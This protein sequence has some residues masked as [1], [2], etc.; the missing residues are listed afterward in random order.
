MDFPSDAA[1][2]QIQLHRTIGCHDLRV[3]E[4]TIR[5]SNH[6]LRAVGILEFHGGE[7][8]RKRFYFGDPW[9]LPTWRGQGVEPYRPPRMR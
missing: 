9:E 5:Y 7:V 2:Q 1:R 4:Y 8:I 3:K 6:S